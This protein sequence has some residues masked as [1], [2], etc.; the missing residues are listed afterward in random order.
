[1]KDGA[2]VNCI[3]VEEI[4]KNGVNTHTPVFIKDSSTLTVTNRGGY[5]NILSPS[6]FN[7]EK[8]LSSIRFDSSTLNPLRPGRVLYSFF[9]GANTP[10]KIDLSNIFGRD[11]KGLARGLLNNNA[12]FFTAS[13]LDS[14]NGIGGSLGNLE[15]T[16]TAKEQ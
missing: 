12:V 8:R 5:S 9:L 3:L 13:N 1:M 16:I 2:K 10:Q 14:T 11:R 6:A 7:S 4:S 15:M